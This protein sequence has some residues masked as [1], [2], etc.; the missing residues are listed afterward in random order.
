VDITVDYFFKKKV[1]V[2][3]Q[4][5]GYRFSID[6]PILA[7]FLP[8]R[9]KEN[10]LEIGSGCGIISILALYKKKFSHITGLEIQKDLCR[11]SK[12]NAE[13]NQLSDS[14]TAINGDFNKLYRDFSGIKWIF[15]NPPFLKSNQGRLS[16]R[17][18]VKI[19]KFEVTLSLSNLMKKSFS[20]LSP[21]GHLCMILPHARFEES[22]AMARD[23]GFFINRIRRVFSFKNGKP[24]RFLIQLSKYRVSI[25]RMNPLI[26][27]EDEDRY[28]EEVN[29]ILEGR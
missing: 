1:V 9:E 24:E 3:Q 4:K 2:L 26:I 11:L 23:C 15:S 13:K 27:F 5:Q 22:I 20:I 16:S 14:F 21:E 8:F 7:H 18:G 12:T 6:S 25:N 10:A 17:E 28:T 29:G 19:A